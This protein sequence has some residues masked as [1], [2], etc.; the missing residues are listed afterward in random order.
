MT[1]E[2]GNKIIAEFMDYYRR[3]ELDDEMLGEAYWK[4]NGIDNFYLSKAQYHTSWDW[5]MP[6]L[7]RIVD[8]FSK[9]LGINKQLEV[10][11]MNL[12]DRSIFAPIE[13]VYADAVAVI[14]YI[15]NTQELP[16]P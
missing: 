3:P 7:K 4:R 11:S 9:E 16:T 15:N 1:V 5:L 12:F 10:L 6:V 13:D 2:E 8:V 14:I